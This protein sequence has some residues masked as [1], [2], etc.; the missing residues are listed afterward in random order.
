V[1]AM[2][3]ASNRAVFNAS[4]L[5]D[6]QPRWELFGTSF[7]IQVLVVSLLVLIPMLMPE[8][9]EI[10]RHYW[11]TPVEAPPVVAWKPQPPPPPV[12]ASPVK[13]VK[14]VPKPA[15][16]PT[17]VAVEIPKPRIYAP[18]N[19]AP[20]ARVNKP[21]NVQAPDMTEVAKA[22]PDQNP[23]MSMGSPAIPTLKKPREAVQ[24]GGF[25]DPD[26]L[27]ANQRTGH[28]ANVNVKGAYDMPTGAG[29]GNG[30]GGANGAKGVIASTGFGNGVA[31]G[32]PGGGAHG[33]VKQGGFGDENAV[34]A[35][36][37][38][39]QTANTV[40]K[41]T[42]ISIIFQPKPVYSDEGR[43]KK[44]EGEVLLQVIFTA[45]GDV[46]V[47]RVVQGLGHG[48]DESA[49]SAARQIRFKPA[50]QDGQPVDT[51]ATIHIVFALAY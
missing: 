39:K 49:Q 2:A 1:K 33:T 27:P 30:T 21:K 9:M 41:S 4:L 36:P 6:A 46:K 8:K 32:S 12:K 25:G 17:P 31:V 40:A 20:V 44:I 28:Q 5:P 38:V 16:V 29:T 3:P 10:V 47:L 50:Q 19:P 18:V 22:F 24:T 7:G 48:L 26:G 23:P 45:S 37:K 13:V 51:T 11:T 15:P 14:E 42:P 35:A 34:V 43:A